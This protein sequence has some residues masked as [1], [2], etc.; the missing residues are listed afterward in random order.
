MV[1]W[2][3]CGILLRKTKRRSLGYTCR[4][5]AGWYIECRF[6]A[7]FVF[8]FLLGHPCGLMMGMIDYLYLLLSFTM[9]MIMMK[10]SVSRVSDGTPAGGSCTVVCC[11]GCYAESRGGFE[12][13]FMNIWMG[14]MGL[15]LYCV[16]LVA[17]MILILMPLL[18]FLC[19]NELLFTC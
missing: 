12:K 17:S 14:W 6:L 10:E 2:I 4:A 1:F 18:C 5:P 13:G 15:F 8:V 9:M 19:L 7:H 3:C 11:D 16:D